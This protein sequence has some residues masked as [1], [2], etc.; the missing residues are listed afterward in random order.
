MKIKISKKNI[1]EATLSRNQLA[2]LPAGADIG[3]ILGRA[4]PP[5]AGSPEFKKAQQKMAQQAPSV[6]S[7]LKR[8]IQRAMRALEDEL[9]KVFKAHMSN[10]AGAETK[11]KAAPEDKTVAGRKRE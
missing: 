4:G 2:N 8:D 5:V 7:N 11:Q 10:I 9:V 1:S 6:S 3:K